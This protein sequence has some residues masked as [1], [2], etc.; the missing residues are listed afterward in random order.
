MLVPTVTPVMFPEP[1]IDAFALLLLHV[2][3]AVALLNEVVTPIHSDVV[4]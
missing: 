1:S 2:P 4:P 3:P